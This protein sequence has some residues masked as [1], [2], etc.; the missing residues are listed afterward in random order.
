MK[1]NEERNEN[2]SPFSLWF[3]FFSLT[4]QCNRKAKHDGKHY[5]N[6]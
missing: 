1:K 3:N 2:S 4:L 5:I 6:K